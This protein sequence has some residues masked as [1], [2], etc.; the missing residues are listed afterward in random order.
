[1]KLA[2]VIRTGGSWVISK[3]SLIVDTPPIGTIGNGALYFS[4]GYRGTLLCLVGRLIGISS[5]YETS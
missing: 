1:M 4:L 3:P 5:R 2:R